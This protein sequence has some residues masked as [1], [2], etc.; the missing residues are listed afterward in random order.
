MQLAHFG[1]AVGVAGIAVVALYS[2]ERDVRMAPGDSAELAGYSFT[3]R[4][5]EPRDGPNYHAMRGIVEVGR[6]GA[7]VATLRPE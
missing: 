6:N 5:A 4:G 7:R 3:F 1:M 2:S